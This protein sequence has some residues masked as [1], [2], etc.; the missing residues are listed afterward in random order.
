VRR[1]LP[2]PTLLTLALL[3]LHG[4]AHACQYNVRD[5]GFVELTTDPYHLYY[6]LPDTTPESL[7]DTLDATT[8]VALL[9]TNL[10]F[11]IRSPESARAMPALVPLLD[12]RDPQLPA[13]A[14][15]SPDQRL[16]PLDLAP[17][18]AAP[19]PE[20]ALQ[21][22]LERLIA[23]PARDALRE[24]AL[25]QF[26]VVLL[27]ESPDPAA[28]TRAAEATQDA[29]TRIHTRMNMLPKPIAKP[30]VM[31]TLTQDHAAAEPILLWALGLD[32]PPA[33]P[34]AVLLYSRV[35]RMGPNIT[36][37]DITP[38]RIEDFLGVVGADCECGLDRKWMQGSMLPIRWDTPLRE[39]LAAS[40][41]FDPEDPMVKT[42]ISILVSKSA[43]G[44]APGARGL[45]A[46]TG[47]RLGYAE[48]TGDDPSQ[49]RGG[50]APAEEADATTDSV[51]ETTP[52]ETLPPAVTIMANTPPAPDAA[53]TASPPAAAPSAP[54][55]A[56]AQAVDDR[57]TRTAL[58]LFPLMAA[59]LLC[60][61]LIS[62]IILWRARATHG[63]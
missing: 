27:L 61:I 10:A 21:G 52:E 19:D 50:E 42:E 56:A 5:V 44:G 46:T 54:A 26:G 49:Q 12:T 35:R 17:V 40:L 11:E 32:A 47:T 34:T 60:S 58:T 45:N 38:K 9:D 7:R 43:K 30:P 37:D 28:N 48:M 51:G 4:A 3:L 6:I 29:L 62:A 23:S 33:Q 8:T 13:A 41:G 15:L 63:R 59:L 24:K 31:H 53:S 25:E 22:F 55:E 39:R 20:A 57:S 18:L 14:L 16:L 2:F 1:K 36:G